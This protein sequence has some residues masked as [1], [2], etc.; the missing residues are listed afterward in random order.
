MEAKEELSKSIGFDYHPFLVT[1]AQSNNYCTL[2]I[3]ISL[4]YCSGVVLRAAHLRLALRNGEMLS[5]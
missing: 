5:C 4:V 2:H 1:P 3:V